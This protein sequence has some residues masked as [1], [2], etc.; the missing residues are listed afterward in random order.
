MQRLRQVFYN[1]VEKESEKTV[2]KRKISLL[3]EERA[4]GE[5]AQI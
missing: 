3:L 5:I 2:K 4:F 1:F